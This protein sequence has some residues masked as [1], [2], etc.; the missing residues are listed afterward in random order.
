MIP[1]AGAGRAGGMNGADAAVEQRLDRRVGMRGAARIVGI[2]DDAGDA[3]IDAADRRQIIADVMVLRP[4]CLG[5]R[6]VCRVHVIGERRRIGIDAAQ[7]RLPGMAVAIDQAW[8]DNAVAG[9][10]DLRAGGIDVWRDRRDFAALD[11]DVARREVADL[12]V[13]GHD[14]A[15]FDQHA[16]RAIDR[17]LA[18]EAADIRCGAGGEARAA[19]GSGP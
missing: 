10:D 6:Q 5:E 18:A 19:R 15:A 9:I 7:L 17:R 13:H 2:I 11:Q 14:G 3:G 8:H 1:L 12:G 16:A 4:I